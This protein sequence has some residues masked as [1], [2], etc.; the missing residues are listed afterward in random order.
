MGIHKAAFDALMQLAKPLD[1]ARPHS[2]TAGQACP[3][4]LANEPTILLES[5]GLAVLYKPPG[6]TVSVFAGGD[7]LE[8]TKMVPAEESATEHAAREV[9]VSK[10][11]DERESQLQHWV[12]KHLGPLYPISADSQAA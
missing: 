5:T 9:V 7:S 12:A 4:I 6:W 3:T 10:S 11:A 8:G 2:I 1:A